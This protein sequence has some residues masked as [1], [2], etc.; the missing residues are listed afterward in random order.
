MKNSIRLFAVL[1]AVAIAA[2]FVSCGLLEGE[3]EVYTVSFSTLQWD[4]TDPDSQQ[5]AEGDRAVEPPKPVK[6]GYR[7]LYWSYDGTTP[8][9]FSA[10]VTSNLALK[11]VWELA[12]SNDIE[13]VEI[14]GVRWATRNLTESGVFAGH[15]SDNG[16]FYQWNRL[17]GWPYN[18]PFSGWN[19]AEPDGTV[20]DKAN[21]PCPDGWRVPVDDDFKRLLDATQV[22]FDY[23]EVTVGIVG[24]IFVDKATG[25]T[26][27]FL[28]GGYI[29][30]M[31]PGWIGGGSV[32]FMFD[33]RI[34]EYWSATA[35]EYPYASNFSMSG[36][37]D[38]SPEL[39]V[40]ARS[41]GHNVRCVKAD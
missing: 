35:A 36:T 4:V 19:F 2:A 30:S 23:F 10:P 24:Q 32:S 26:V 13:G 9:D 38:P 8:Y 39:L 12:I 41:P 18:G 20:W 17:K 5:V 37:S 34:G 3:K 7:L 25:N 27:F 22:A 6:L 28:Y 14:N 33:R 1:A 11:A 29:M 40:G 21:D 16:W 31:P 15:Y